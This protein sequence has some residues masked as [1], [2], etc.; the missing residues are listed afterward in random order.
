MPLWPAGLSRVRPWLI[1]YL[2]WDGKTARQAWI[3][4]PS[5]W[6][7]SSPPSPAPL[8]ISPHGRNNLGWNNAVSYWQNLPADGRFVLVCPDG[9]GRAH[10]Q[11]SDPFDQPPTNPGL[12]S[13]V[14]CHVMSI[15]PRWLASPR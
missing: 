15:K 2:G 9:L 3:I 7:P 5:G 6:D 12:F 1:H 10:D 4:L 14:P 8:V 13:S 11:A